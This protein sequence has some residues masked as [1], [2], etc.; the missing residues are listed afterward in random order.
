MGI[1]IL[2]PDLVQP[3][4]I[5]VQP[6]MSDVTD[7]IPSTNHGV[8]VFN[9]KLANVLAFLVTLTLNGISSAGLISEFGV[10][11]ISRKYPTRITPA[12]GAFGIWGYIYTLQAAFI[13]YQFFWPKDD[14]ATLLHGVGFWYISA[15]MFNSLW[16]VTFVQ[17]NTA[18]IWCSTFLI[19]GLLASICKIYINTG[20]WRKARPGGIVQAIALD[21]HFSMYAGWV[22]VATIVNITVALT[23]VWD[24]DAATASACTVVMLVVALLLNTLIVLTRRDCVWGWVLCWASYFI[25]ESNT[26]DDAIYTGSLVVSVLIGLVSAAVGV[27]TTVMFVRAKN[28]SPTLPHD[29]QMAAAPGQQLDEE[30]AAAGPAGV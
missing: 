16:I 8:S 22:T 2:W 25:S 11:T 3:I 20:C 24:A 7:A 18:A 9:L 12:S 14:E 30:K 23:T 28:D 19:A 6:I 1:D 17:G 13:I 15:C 5:L 10:G 21:V 27:H 26:G 29:S 4:I